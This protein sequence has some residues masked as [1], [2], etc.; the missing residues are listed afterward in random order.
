MA[1][2]GITYMIFGNVMVDPSSKFIT[3]DQQDWVSKAIL[4]IQVSICY[5]ISNVII[6]TDGLLGWINCSVYDCYPIERTVITGQ[7]GAC[8]G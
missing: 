7:A 5:I 1:A 2:L 4:G 8:F 6:L 3:A